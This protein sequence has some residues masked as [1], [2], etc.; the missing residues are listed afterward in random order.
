MN[1][2]LEV[3]R[4]GSVVDTRELTGKDHH[5]MGR[6]PDNGAEPITLCWPNARMVSHAGAGTREITWECVL[7]AQTSCWSIRPRRGCTR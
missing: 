3:L 1:Y 4:D 5:T 7:V 6:T 2:T